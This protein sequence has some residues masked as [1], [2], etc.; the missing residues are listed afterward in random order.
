MDENLKG[1]NKKKCL[2][3]L[4]TPVP[5]LRLCFQTMQKYEVAKVV[6]APFRLEKSD[7]AVNTNNANDADDTISAFSFDN[8]MDT[9]SLLGLLT[10][11]PSRTS[12]PVV[13]IDETTPASSNAVIVHHPVGL[14]ELFRQV[15]LHMLCSRWF[16]INPLLDEI[17][18]YMNN[19]EMCLFTTF[20]LKSWAELKA[21]DEV[22]ASL[23]D[24]RISVIQGTLPTLTALPDDPKPSTDNFVNSC[25]DSSIPKTDDD[26]DDSLVEL[27]Y[28]LPT[29]LNETSKDICYLDQN[30]KFMNL[31][32]DMDSITCAKVSDVKVD[33]NFNIKKRKLYERVNRPWKRRCT[34]NEN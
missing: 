10:G 7:S 8:P 9:Q 17:L 23:C 5:L 25:L 15:E 29:T 28:C 4:E 22:V 16:I 19:Q 32:F 31:R 14:K 24:T 26:S 33:N 20:C 6:L 12:S 3:Q 1:I 13:D 21:I 18:F 27:Y 2:S 11:Y 34:A 30:D